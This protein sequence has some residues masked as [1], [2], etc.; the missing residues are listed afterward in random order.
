MDQQLKS[1]HKPAEFETATLI[2]IHPALLELK[3]PPALTVFK[4]LN[5]LSSRVH[6]HNDM[7][8]A[9]NDYTTLHH[10]LVWKEH[11]SSINKFFASKQNSHLWL[12]NFIY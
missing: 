11:I 4:P 1:V 5:F 6:I 8:A 3:K 12:S 10:L 7:Q 9:L 2:S